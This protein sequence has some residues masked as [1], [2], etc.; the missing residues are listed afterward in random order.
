MDKIEQNEL[1]FAKKQDQIMKMRVK[2]NV[3]KLKRTLVL[4]AAG[5]IFL[6]FVGLFFMLIFQT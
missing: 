1:E 5:L 4:I 2:R 6:L 3:A